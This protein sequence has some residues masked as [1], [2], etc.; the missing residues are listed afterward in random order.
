M[1]LAPGFDDVR[2]MN[3]RIISRDLWRHRALPCAKGM[4]VGRPASGRLA[5]R[6]RPPGRVEQEPALR[7]DDADETDWLVGR[8]GTRNHLFRVNIAAENSTVKPNTRR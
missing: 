1:A 4:N 7:W 3:N 8:A 6:V 5:A 2:P